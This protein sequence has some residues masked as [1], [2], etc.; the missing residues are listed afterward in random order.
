[1]HD[2]VAEPDGSSASSWG[3]PSEGEGTWVVNPHCSWAWVVVSDTDIPWV[4]HAKLGEV[5]TRSR[6]SKSA[7][8]IVGN[9]STALDQESPEGKV[10]TLGWTK[11]DCV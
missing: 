7:D 10:S 3:S 9:L 8:H 2:G 5:V 1:M 4:A 11:G 6:I